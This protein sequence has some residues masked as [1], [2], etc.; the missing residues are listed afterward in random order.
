ME[1]IKIYGYVFDGSI[2]F[3]RKK[4]EPAVE[5]NANVTSLKTMGDLE[6][7]LQAM[8]GPTSV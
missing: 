4:I 7:D 6:N 3:N 1:Y 8:D 2:N 5:L